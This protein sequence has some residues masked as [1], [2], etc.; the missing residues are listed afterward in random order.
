MGKLAAVTCETAKPD[1]KR[2]R[3]LGMAMAYS[4]ECGRTEP[5]HG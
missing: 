2:D 4:C 3:L 5:K 1:K